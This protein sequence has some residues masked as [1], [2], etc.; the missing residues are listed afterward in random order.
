MNVS[1]KK[2]IGTCLLAGIVG[3]WLFGDGNESGTPQGTSKPTEPK[4]VPYESYKDGDQGVTGYLFWATIEK[5]PDAYQFLKKRAELEKKTN[6][7]LQDPAMAE[8][9]ISVD[10]DSNFFSEDQFVKYDGARLNGS[11]AFVYIGEM[12]GDKP[13]GVG[14]LLLKTVSARALETVAFFDSNA[15]KLQDQKLND[16]E[17]YSV[18]Y[19]GHF[20]NG[21]FDGYGLLYKEFSTRD[22]KKAFQEYRKKDGMVNFPMFIKYEG[23][24]SDGKY[25]G[26]GN[27]YSLRYDIV[28]QEDQ[29]YFANIDQHIIFGFELESGKFKDGK[30]EGV[31]NIYEVKDNEVVRKEQVEFEAGKQKK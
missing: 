26:K 29:K 20:S 28:Q 15:K 22:Q 6:T 2:V 1:F 12:D 31:F 3:V 11:P 23:E 30:K 17:F 7:F 5:T 13:D 24:F 16:P 4:K 21:R 10:Y 9:A 27:C 19:K 14:V 18:L 25:D 8:K